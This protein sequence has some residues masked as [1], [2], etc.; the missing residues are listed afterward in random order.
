MATGVLRIV[1]RY[2]CSER[3][4]EDGQFG[5]GSAEDVRVSDM[6]WRGHVSA[7]WPLSM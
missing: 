6:S 4:E 5:D 2:G 1:F 3:N 7:L